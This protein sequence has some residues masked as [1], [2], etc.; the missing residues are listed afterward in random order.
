MPTN[1]NILVGFQAEDKG[2]LSYMN[3]LESE[4]DEIKKQ[5]KDLVNQSNRFTNAQQRQT[6]AIQKGSSS[7]R[8]AR[9]GM[10][11]FGYQVQDIAVQLQGGQNLGLIIGQQGSQIA[12]IFGTGGIVAGAIVSI[13]ALITTALVPKL[14]EAGQEAKLLENIFSDLK[15]TMLDTAQNG[16]LVLSDSFIELYNRNRQLAELQLRGKYLDAL[17]AVRLSQQG[18]VSSS[19]D[20]IFAQARTGNAV[21]G[22][23]VILNRFA[24]EMGIT[25]EQALELRNAAIAVR[26]GEEGANEALVNLLTTMEGSQEF[27]RIAAEVAEFGISGLTAADNIDVLRGALENLPTSVDQAIRAQTRMQE[28][29]VG[30]TLPELPTGKEFV[31]PP[32]PDSVAIAAY[33]AWAARQAEL[34]QKEIDD[35]A[36]YIQE[37]TDLGMTQT[38]AIQTEFDRRLEQLTQFKDQELI[39]TEQYNAAIVGAEAARQAQLT[40]IQEEETKRREQQ[41]KESIDSIQGFSNFLMS[42][43]DE[44]TALYKAAFIANQ[45][46]KISQAIVDTEAAAAAALAYGGPA[47]PA[48]SGIIRAMGYASVG[49]MAAQTVSSFE[50]GG[51]TGMGS[52]TGGIDGKGGFAAI[53]HP[54]E[55]VID[56]T[57]GQ[58]ATN[59]NITINAADTKDFDRLLVDRR[60]TLINI[61]NQA[62]NNRGRASIT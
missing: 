33:E 24:N 58:A 22:N 41:I 17:E 46:I 20:L 14:F 11:Q 37:L 15:G 29:F 7:M 54:N 13:G 3:K 43:L 59:V 4:L 57:K 62:V 21:R 39:T 8:V 61:I 49:V 19:R 42:S 35:A 55:T 53:L 27:T 1:E 32:E 40:A 36:K 12:S 45:A 44:S 60:S 47:G 10:A 34:K 25:T 48:L 16:V 18:L 28:G 38:E 51:F 30:P 6:K 2:L 56:H 31:G 52:R 23:E 5:H 26:N 9:S 50:G